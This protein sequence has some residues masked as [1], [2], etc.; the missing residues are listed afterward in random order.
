MC[1]QMLVPFFRWFFVEEMSAYAP[2]FLRGPPTH[3][4]LLKL[5]SKTWLTFGKALYKPY[6][7]ME[8]MEKK[9]KIFGRKKVMIALSDRV[10]LSW[11]YGT[12]A[13]TLTRNIEDFFIISSLY[14][15]YISSSLVG[16][17]KHTWWHA[18]AIIMYFG[19]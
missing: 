3:L 2:I 12:A 6:M 19:L 13:W 18:V 4:F 1:F 11:G 16:S 8:Y 7:Y 10:G 9:A 14:L 5:I 17:Q 15:H